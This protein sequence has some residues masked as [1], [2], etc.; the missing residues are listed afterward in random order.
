MKKN[1]SLSAVLLLL[2]LFA[3]AATG[4][5][6]IRISAEKF[7][8]TSFYTNQKIFEDAFI[9]AQG[10]LVLTASAG[11]LALKQ[12]VKETISKDAIY[13]WKQASK[14]SGR[15]VF[16]EIREGDKCTT[17]WKS[18]GNNSAV[19][20]EQW[21]PGIVPDS[22]R[23]I[24][25]S[26]AVTANTAQE[27]AVISGTIGTYFFK[28]ILDTALNLSVSGS[29]ASVG[30]SAKA[31]YLITPLWDLNGGIQLSLTGNGDNSAF[32]MAALIGASNFL[33]YRSSLDFSASI[34]NTGAFMIG[35][36]VTYYF[37]GRPEMGTQPAPIKKEDVKRA[38]TPLFTA[39]EIP[40]REEEPA[41]TDTPRPE[42][43]PWPTSTRVPEATAT[44]EPT[45]EIIPTVGA[46]NEKETEAT[47]AEIKAQPE[48]TPAAR[49]TQ[50]RVENTGADVQE[51][52][53]DQKEGTTAG[54]FM[55]SDILNLATSIPDRWVN[56]NLTFGFGTDSIFGMSITPGYMTL[57]KGGPV[58]Y[59][60][61]SVN[62]ALDFY[63]LGRSPSGIYLGPVVG[64]RHYIDAVHEP[65]DVTNTE[66]K[67]LYGGQAGVRV[68]AA[69]FVMDAAAVYMMNESAKAGWPSEMVNDLKFRAGIGIM[70]Y[71][72][73]E[74]GQES[75]EDIKEGTT[76]GTFFEVDGMSA[77]R[78]MKNDDFEGDVRF[79]FGDDGILGM[80]FTL[81][82]KYIEQFGFQKYSAMARLALDLYPFDR[83]PSGLYFGALAGAGYR[84]DR[85][86]FGMGY[87]IDNY[88]VLAAGGEA[89][90]RILM[91]MLVLDIAIEYDIYTYPLKARAMEIQEEFIM[92]AGVGLMF[93]DFKKVK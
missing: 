51:R 67:V 47:P 50:E 89:G 30:L 92:R 71:A 43:T 4:A 33:S 84:V 16:V 59:D 5:E 54:F 10:N 93:Y 60:L 2:T 46:S 72:G 65:L 78:M 39:T 81:G 88:P 69:G 61:L 37:D 56:I 27:G 83:S 13:A 25:M 12:G 18:E 28:D 17:L 70:F 41:P 82:G 9:S 24:F 23:R 35:S 29:S 34:G 26:G 7:K 1:I 87:V 32:E 6:D 53:A 76:E 19:M 85:Q 66:D 73:D 62:V 75:D 40:A 58:T 11:F 86:D 44:N 21:G 90:L 64:F 48:E 15:A 74:N 55:E 68:L 45:Q 57:E 3:S 49:E 14:I 63:P 38:A 80:N 52:P 22:G 77:Y 91:N 42:S 8:K 36:G 79:G 20:V 31:H